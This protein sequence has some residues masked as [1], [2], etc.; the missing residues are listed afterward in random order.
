V[1]NN[2][3]KLSN[4]TVTAESVDVF[5]QRLDAEWSSRECKLNLGATE[6]ATAPGQ[7]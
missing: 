2:W 3:N 6:D 1:V 4:E 7:Q 5:K